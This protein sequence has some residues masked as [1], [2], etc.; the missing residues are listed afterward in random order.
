MAQEEQLRLAALQL[1]DVVHLAE[2]SR[3]VDVG[4]L[5]CTAA[6]ARAKGAVSRRCNA[7]Q[8]AALP[9]LAA[10]RAAAVTLAAAAAAERGP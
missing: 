10:V 8:L 6:G 2:G 7:T 1:R 3:L 9:Y 5:D 4:V